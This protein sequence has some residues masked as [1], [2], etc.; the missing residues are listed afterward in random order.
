M[1]RA[2]LTVKMRDRKNKCCEYACRATLADRNMLQIATA[3]LSEV[4]DIS[5]TKYAGEMF[6]LSLVKQNAAFLALPTPLC[7]KSL[8]NAA[9]ELVR[10]AYSR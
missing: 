6:F 2:V 8:Y 5:K 9:I 7:G 3:T 1:D 10:L 4:S